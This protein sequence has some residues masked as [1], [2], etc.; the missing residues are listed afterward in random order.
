MEKSH[1]LTGDGAQIEP[2]KKGAVGALPSGKT[3]RKLNPIRLACNARSIF[4]ALPQAYLS[5]YVTYRLQ[6]KKDF[7]KLVLNPDV[8]SY[9]GMQMRNEPSLG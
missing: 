1:F 5:K 2:P 3:P 6:G 4:F 9:P 7:I 8:Q